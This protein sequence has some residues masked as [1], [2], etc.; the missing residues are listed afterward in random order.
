MTGLVAA[1]GRLH[2]EE[3]PLSR[4]ALELMA[5]TVMEIKLLS[6]QRFAQRVRNEDFASA[7]FG[8]DAGSC[9]HG[10]TADLLAP[11]L[12]FA[13]VEAGSGLQAELA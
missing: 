12:D 3:L 4:D 1:P 7:A 8:H 13:E 2:G 6:R 11:H 5:T 10:E 9:V